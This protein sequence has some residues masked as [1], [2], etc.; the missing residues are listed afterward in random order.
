MATD[1]ELQAWVPDEYLD[2]LKCERIAEP[3][4]T[5]AEQAREILQRGAP[6]AAH[7][8]VHLSV[9]GRD[10]K[11]RLQAARY[12]L[13]G[14]VSQGGTLLPAEN[15]DD[16]LAQLVAKLADNDPSEWKQVS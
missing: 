15:I 14:I 8:V 4:K 7:A 16:A 5:Y 13:D 11:M 6:M 3:D 1:A 10:E 2:L 9:Y 12:I